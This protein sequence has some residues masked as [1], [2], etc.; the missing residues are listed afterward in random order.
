MGRTV[1]L[2][3]ETGGDRLDRFLAILCP[4]ISRSRLQS[5]IADGQVAVDGRMTGRPASRLKAGQTVTFTIPDPT[6]GDVLEAQPL[7]LNVVYE[8]SDLLVVDKPAGLTVHPAPGHPDRTLANAL[9]A[10]YP[11]IRDVGGELKAGIVHRL[12]R[13]TSGLLV[14]AKN[15]A[16][17]ADLSRQFSERLVTKVYTALVHG[18]PETPEA[19]IEAPIGR[20]PRDRKRM[21]VVSIGRQST[22]RYRALAYYDGYTL[23]EAR[24]ATGRTHQI[25]VHMASI[26]HPVAGDVTYGSQNS[27]LDR[28]F[29]HARLLGFAHPST[30]Q[31]LEVQAELPPDLTS[32][33]NNLTP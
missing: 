19:V 11:K 8:D 31:Y 1:E 16:A 15:E 24:P 10:R 13:G 28:P 25:R 2:K 27:K 22:T 5:L 17:H 14:V 20:H 32:F 26:G 3:V 6:A 29:L 23:I 21:A 7:P 33:L 12:D 9:L 4:D 30:G 18:R